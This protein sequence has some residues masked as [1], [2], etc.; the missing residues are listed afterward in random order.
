MTL[1]HEDHLVQDEDLVQVD[2]P[3]LGQEV[4]VVPG[5]LEVHL[6]DLE[7]LVD[8]VDLVDLHLTADTDP[9]IVEDQASI[10]HPLTATCHLEVRS[11]CDCF[12]LLLVQYIFYGFF[13]NGHFI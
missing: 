2:R 8:P 12:R 7:D 11:G 6:E 4:L 3:F 10:L 1:V 5:V 13:I 9:A